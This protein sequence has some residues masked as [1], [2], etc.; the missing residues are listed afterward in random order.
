MTTMAEDEDEDD[1]DEQEV[2]DENDMMQRFAFG[3]A[4]NRK[5]N[6]YNRSGSP[7]NR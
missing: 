1:Y 2:D 4:S 3:C 6:E 5:L 7:A